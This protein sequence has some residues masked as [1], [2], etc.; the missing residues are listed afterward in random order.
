MTRQYT[1]DDD[2]IVEESYRK[3]FVHIRIMYLHCSIH[4]DTRHQFTDGFNIMD[5]LWRRFKL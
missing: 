3:M 4:I 2:V 5:V 1:Q